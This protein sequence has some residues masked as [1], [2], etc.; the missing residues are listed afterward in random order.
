MMRTKSLVCGMMLACSAFLLANLAAGSDTED[1]EKPALSGIWTLKDGETKIEFS[2]HNVMTISPH[3]D[4]SVIAVVCEYTVEKE[5][6]VQ[7]KI[8]DVGGKEEAKEVVK[9]MLPVGTEFHF[10]WRANRDTAKL[11]QVKGEKIEPL[12]SHLEG[13]YRQQN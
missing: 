2:D 11:E 6:R 4:P 13:E 7:A 10:I 3:G 8:T 12:K 1:R 9:G 5:G